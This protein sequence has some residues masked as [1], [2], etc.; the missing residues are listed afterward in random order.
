MVFVDP[1]LEEKAD[2]HF[3]GPYYPYKVRGAK[4]PKFDVY[5]GIVLDLKIDRKAAALLYFYRR[6]N[7]LV[8]SDITVC[9]VPS[10]DPEKLETGIRLL[11]M[12]LALNNR[13][14]GT[15][16]LVRTKSVTKATAG[17]PR[18]VAV[19]KDSTEVREIEKVRD[20]EILLLDDVTTS[21]ASMIAA[22]ELLIAAGAASVKC[23]ALGKTTH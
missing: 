12:R 6:I 14:D 10:S 15:L 16:C 20:A 4:N 2:V 3:L 9:T 1:A 19:H 17:G 23:L 21:G 18:S 7:P 8:H 13:T 11:G 22:K 5:S